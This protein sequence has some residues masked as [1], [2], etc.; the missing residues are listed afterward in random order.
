MKIAFLS[1]YLDTLG[2]GEKYLL[3]IALACHTLHFR[4]VFLWKDPAIKQKLIQDFGK[5]YDFIEID[6]SW[7]NTNPFSRM[8]KSREYDVIFYHPD[9]SYFY[10]LARKNFALLQVPDT[11]LLPKD[12]FFNLQKFNRWTP[13]FNSHF[14]KRF[15]ARRLPIKNPVVLYP[16]V[17]D[18]L[19][20]KTNLKKTNTIL[21]V[22][23]FF[24]YLHSKRHDVLIRA[25]LHGKE[26]YPKEFNK[27]SLVLVGAF[28]NED[29]KYLD[30]IRQM[31]KADK[32]ISIKPNASHE[33]LVTLYRQSKFYWHAAGYGADEKKEP[34]KME[35][36]GISIVEA[37]ASGSVP[38]SF[39][40]GGPTETI[41][42]GK[43]GY[44][45]KKPIDLVDKT[46]QLINNTKLLQTISERARTRAVEK[47]SFASFRKSIQQLL[48]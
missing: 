48:K 9:G 40:A 6:T 41:L 7:H 3:D 23:R 36:F 38:Y 26:K 13:V 32:S 2:G 14:T 11:N 31:A 4:T 10:S 12:G 42:D 8:N 33:E 16:T 28:K 37:M 29:K 43:T 17:S 46:H 25:F 34:E 20:E 1:P 18:E 21:S 24:K 39:D 47:F 27:Y 19:F 15:F 45:Y 22:G 44:L 30:S 35:H 5:T